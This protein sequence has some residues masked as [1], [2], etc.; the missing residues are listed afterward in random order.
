[1]A[2]PG[3]KQYAADRHATSETQCTG[4]NDDATDREKAGF[5]RQ[6]GSALRGSDLVVAALAFLQLDQPFALRV[7]EQVGEAS[8]AVVAFGEPRVDAL[9]RLLDDGAPD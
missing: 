5:S 1:M 4:A 7:R 2:V 3:R 9:Q 6:S 8:I